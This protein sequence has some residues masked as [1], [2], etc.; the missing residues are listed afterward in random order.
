MPAIVLSGGPLH[1]RAR[2]LT[3]SLEGLRDAIADLDLG[4][5]TLRATLGDFEVH[6][7]ARLAPA[8]EQMKRIES[9]VRMLDGWAGI[10]K[11]TTKR[12][13]K[14]EGVKVDARR[15]KD[16]AASA[17]FRGQ[18]QSRADAP[19]RAEVI[20]TQPKLSAKTEASRI[21][22]V[23]AVYRRLARRFHPDLAR[24]EDE[25]LIAGHMMARVNL[26]YRAHDLERLV[27]LEKQTKA[28]EV[29]DSSLPIEEQIAELEVR[30]AWFQAV[31]ENLR[32]ERVALEKSP[33]C[34]LYRNVEQAAEVSRDLVE[35]LLR[36]LEARV[37]RAYADIIDAAL[38]LERH[39]AVY[40]RDSTTLDNTANRESTANQGVVKRASGAL[41]QVFDPYTDKGLVRLGLDELATARVSKPARALADRF[42]AYADSE[43]TVLSLLLLTYASE[44]CP[45]PLAG[46]ESYEHIAQRL[47]YL[48]QDSE[49]T[50]CSFEEALVALDDVL[51]F[52]VKNVTQKVAYAGLRFVDK[53]ASTAIAVALQRASVRRSFRGVLGVLGELVHCNGCDREVFSIPLYRTRGLDDLRASICPRCA[54][55]HSS[56]WMPKGKDV[57][58][59]LNPTYLDYE[60]VQEW[61]FELAHLSIGMQL[62]PVQTEAMTVGD[63]KKRFYE[64]TLERHQI[65]VSRGQLA[66]YQ[67]GGK[68]PE[69]T[70][71]AGLSERSFVV[72]FDGAKLRERDALELIRHRIR[73]RFK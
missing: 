44:K 19:L 65:E 69:K 17:V 11:S 30:E 45:F 46:L 54:T 1:E 6:Y 9:Y 50:P 26:L 16:V 10:L 58:A 39:V 71:L 14:S 13:V 4:I 56:Y 22:E 2:E 7:R 23:K 8:H 18:Q 72:Q 31:L 15:V 27:A 36:E 5:E 43:P 20:D 32:E 41:T 63:L 51:Q 28:G 29:D 35:E 55:T 57:Q 70:K 61:T 49:G 53:D 21:A 64:D 62:L 3:R 12:V 67:G 48:D 59:V 42:E 25:R 68:V 60:L 40:N 37:A 52:G 34:E 38:R 33:T 47:T 66:L 24:T 73:N